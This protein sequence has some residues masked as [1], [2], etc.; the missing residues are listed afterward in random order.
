MRWKLRTIR[1]RLLVGLGAITAALLVC[2]LISVRA[3]EGVS[4]DMRDRIES[5]NTLSGTLFR[6]YDAALRYV[7]TAQAA[8]MDDSGARLAQAESLS[9]AA[10]SLRRVLL[11][12]RE[13]DT[14]D[15]S[16]IEQLGALQGRLEVRFAVARAYLD[17]GDRESASRQASLATA[18]LDSLFVATSHLGQAQEER[19]RAALVQVERLVRMRRLLLWGLAALATLIALLLGIW[20][21]RAITRPLDRLTIAARSLGA[22]D[23]R[24]HIPTMGLDEEYQVLASAFGSM[25]DRLRAVVAEIQTEATEIARAADALT[26]ASEQA[27]SSTGQISEAMAGVARDAEAQ[28]QRFSSSEG[29]LVHVGNSTRELARVA[30]RSRDLGDEIRATSMRTRAGIA[31]ALEV[32][33]RARRVIDGSREEVHQ[34]ETAFGAVGRFVGAIQAVADQTNLL[35]LNAAIEAARAGHAGRGFAVVAEEVRKLAEESGRAADEVNALV[36]GMRH[37]IAA[38]SSAFSQGVNELGDVGAVSRT[39][40]EALEAVA[41]AVK[42]VDEVAASV[43]SAASSHE[44]ALEQLVDNMSAAGG[45]AETQAATSQEAAAAA[46]ETAATAE[47]VAATAQQLAS[48][49]LRLE[50]LVAAFKV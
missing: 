25:A 16:A 39:A 19:T 10:D 23:L 44:R 6:G 46:E 37:R 18:T 35:A 14:E 31:E 7:A 28:R 40:V 1:A 17:V 12:N 30:V 15:R 4:G 43:S 38:T 47:E 27:A 36:V 24:V 5:A 3:L 41:E 32:L 2:A 13:L 9:I 22:G 34:L 42:G 50:S 21:W 49:A 33:E 8:L 11:G 48:N 45:Q 26:S 20:T 29:V